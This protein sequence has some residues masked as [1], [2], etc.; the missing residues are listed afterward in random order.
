MRITG[1]SSTLLTV[2]VDTQLCHQTNILGWGKNNQ[3]EILTWAKS[4]ELILLVQPS[5]AAAE[6]VFSLLQNS[7]PIIS[8][9]HISLSVMLESNH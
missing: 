7:Y 5:S 8:E 2:A 1:I 3:H 9:D 6:G 4:F